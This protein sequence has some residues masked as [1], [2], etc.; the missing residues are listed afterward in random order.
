[1]HEVASQ[2]F[3]IQPSPVSEYLVNTGDGLQFYQTPELDRVSEFIER[4]VPRGSSVH[5]LAEA[6][7]LF[8]FKEEGDTPA[9][10]FSADSILFKVLSFVCFQGLGVQFAYYEVPERRS[11]VAH[12]A[13]AHPDNPSETVPNQ[14]RFLYRGTSA[15]YCELLFDVPA[16]S[17]RASATAALIARNHGSYYYWSSF[18]EPP[19]SGDLVLYLRNGQRKMLVGSAHEQFSIQVPRIREGLEGVIDDVALEYALAQKQWASLG[20]TNASKAALVHVSKQIGCQI[21]C[22][23]NRA[24]AGPR[25]PRLVFPLPPG[26]DWIASKIRSMN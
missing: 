6:E 15:A 7:S 10:V 14:P 16:S 23:S 17:E 20:E 3:V 13:S 24:D 2:S 18:A 26:D 11:I 12:Y 8:S 19:S 9:A 25:D 4:H 21:R 5:L 1:L 22:Y